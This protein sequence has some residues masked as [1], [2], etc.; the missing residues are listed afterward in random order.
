MGGLAK[1]RSWLRNEVLGPIFFLGLEVEE[2][3]AMVVCGYFVVSSTPDNVQHVSV[4]KQ[5][6]G[7]AETNVDLYN[8]LGDFVTFS[9]YNPLTLSVGLQG[10]HHS[11]SYSNI[12]GIHYYTLK[13]LVEGSGPDPACWVPNKTARGR[14]SLK[15]EVTPL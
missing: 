5:G 6:G 12:A 11:G 9:S 13:A 3:V 7:F 8:T 1:Q 10:H 4:V 14:Q 15:T 2:P